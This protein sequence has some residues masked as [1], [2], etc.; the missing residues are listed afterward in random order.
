MSAVMSIDFKEG[1]QYFCE[2]HAD[3]GVMA[4]LVEFGSTNKIER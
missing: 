3:L 1:R 2:A 4:R